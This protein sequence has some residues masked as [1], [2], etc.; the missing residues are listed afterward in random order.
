M[1]TILFKRWLGRVC[2]LANSENPRCI[3]LYYHAI[4]AGPKAIP[5][6]LFRSQMEWLATHAEVLSL[7]ELLFGI[8]KAPLRAAIT[9]DDGYAS[10]AGEADPVLRALDLP[11]T[12]YLNTGLIGDSDRHASDPALGH[13]PDE[14]F[15]SWKD[16][17]LL[18][19]R[20]WTIGSHGVEHLDL[21]TVDDARM[22]VELRNS[23]QS[24]EDRL[25]TECKHFAYT[26]GR[27]TRRVQRA[28]ADAGYH[29]AVAAIHGPVR[30][31]GDPLA[32]P[33]M[34]ISKEYSPEDFRAIV[35]GHWDFLGG[36]HSARRVV[37][38][39]AWR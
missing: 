1:N 30:R 35:Q 6:R 14:H 17:E 24:I 31:L 23:K 37:Q 39:L 16:V 38:R 10:V 32:I 26:W 3:I 18:A 34:D 36:I 4:G 27:Y 9:F 20:R 12:I 25:G 15:M 5:S 22:A 33:R 28:V 21:T 13:Y 11:A 8:S 19:T 7:D 29:T 2:R